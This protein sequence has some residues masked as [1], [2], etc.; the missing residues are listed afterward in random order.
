MGEYMTIIYEV[1]TSLYLNIT[2]RCTNH[3]LFCIR[4]SQ[5]GVGS[6]INLWLDR[7]PT[8]A[9]ILTA[10]HSVD[11]TGYSEFVFCGYGEPMVRA[12]DV[13]ELSRILKR[14]YP[15]PIRINTN[16]QANL[17]C[18]KDITAQLAGLVDAV[19]ISLNA[20]NA[21]EYQLLC[22]SQYGEAAFP[23]L[24]DFAAKCSTYI[25][26]VTLSVVDLMEKADIEACREIAR[27][28]DVGFK[29]R[30]YQEGS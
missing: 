6:D 3:C 15:T 16:G 26:S 10:I 19:S 1:G 20:K 8:V 22:L 11:V 13:I 29:I 9:E 14:L 5:D 23:A 18:G 7:E 21:Q 27:Q 4:N 25:P 24:L 2:N 12:Y 17:I 30:H 28:I